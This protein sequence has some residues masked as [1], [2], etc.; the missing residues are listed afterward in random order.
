MAVLYVAFYDEDRGMTGETYIG[1]WHGT[2]DWKSES[3]KLEVPDHGPRG[4][5]SACDL[6][7]RHGRGLVC[8]RAR[9][10]GCLRKEFSVFPFSV[11]SRVVRTESPKLNTE[12]SKHS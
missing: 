11:F 5:R 12:I 8:E 10:R 6:L 1:P 9:W 4:D 3:K 7:S 2:S